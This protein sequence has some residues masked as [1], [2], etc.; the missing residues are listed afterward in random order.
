[1]K[2]FP[3]GSLKV[4]LRPHVARA[5]RGQVALMVNPYVFFYPTNNNLG[6]FMTPY[7]L[8]HYLFNLFHFVDLICIPGGRAKGSASVLCAPS[9]WLGSL[10]SWWQCGPLWVCCLLS[11]RWYTQKVSVNAANTI[12]TKW[13][14]KLIKIGNVERY[15]DVKSSQ[16][17]TPHRTP[18]YWVSLV[19]PLRLGDAYIRQ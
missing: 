2:R 12:N 11:P 6:W 16:P 19:N 5:T 7:K 4:T 14:K 13:R 9:L 17:N 3:F 10:P 15:S 8:R 18:F 1:M